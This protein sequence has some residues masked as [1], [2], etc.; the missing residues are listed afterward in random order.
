LPPAEPPPAIVDAHVVAVTSSTAVI[1]WQTNVATRG[2]T[3]FGL[4]APTIWTEPDDEIALEHESVLA[5]LEATTTYQVYLHAVD[6]E[7]RA[8]DAALAVTT[9]PPPE[10][11]AART[12]GGRIVVDDSPFYGR[13]VWKPC[14]DGLASNLDDGINLFI[15][16]GCSRDDRGLPGRLD[17][18]GYS[19]VSA[20]DADAA[21]RGVIGFYYPDE[22]D[23]FLESTVRRLDLADALVAPRA[24]RISFLTLT[25][26]FYSRAEPLPQGKGMYP[27]LFAIPD[28]IGF[29]LYPLQGWCRPAFADVFDAQ[30]ELGR[31]SGGKPTFQW[32]EVAPMEHVCGTIGTLDPTPATV[33]AETWLAIAGGADSVGYFPNRWSPSIGAEITRTNAQIKALTPALLAP[34]IDA[35]SDNPAIRVS[36]RT[37]NGGLYVIA[38]NTAATTVATRISVEEI[39]GRSAAILGEDQPAAVVS[40][41][42]GF[43]A[44]LDP[45]TARVYV[46]PPPGW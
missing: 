28:V 39:E 45:L 14:S 1:S 38:V 10:A 37:L 2:R 41:A 40:D 13:A 36:A 31:V 16:D 22:W 25:N 9:G 23:A 35:S 18:R 34:E 4:D 42:G 20:A 21:G 12:A 26:H 8:A 17:G 29:D 3:A 5:G 46:F 7:Q 44:S 27:L 43:A 6:P 33:R 32:I 11:S 24:G 30:R 15:G 19:L